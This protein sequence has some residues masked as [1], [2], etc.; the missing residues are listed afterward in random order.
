MD[1]Y[2]NRYKGKKNIT[3]RSTSELA[4]KE[5]LD[6][7]KVSNIKVFDNDL[8][9]VSAFTPEKFTP[10]TAC[11]VQDNIGAEVFSKIVD[12]NKRENCDAYNMT[13]PASNG[14]GGVR[15]MK[16]TI[17]ETGA[18]PEDLSYINAHETST[19]YHDKFEISTI[20]TVLVKRYIT[21]L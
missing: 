6:A 11:L 7:I 21:F 16:L 19:T 4:T 20:K 13:A 5:A 14:E 8:L 2:E 15:A 17:K 12:L 9:L 1:L 3:G 18:K 10:S